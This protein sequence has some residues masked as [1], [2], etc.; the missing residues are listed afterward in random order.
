M[1]MLTM[2]L[3]PLLLRVCQLTSCAYWYKFS[4]T[5]SSAWCCV[6]WCQ[7]QC[8]VLRRLERWSSSNRTQSRWT[9]SLYRRPCSLRAEKST[10][11][12]R[13]RRWQTGSS[14]SVWSLL[15]VQNTT[16][17][18]SWTQNTEMTTADEV[19]STSTGGHRQKWWR[20]A[21]ELL[22]SPRPQSLTVHTLCRGHMWNKI[23]SKLFHPSSTSDWNTFISECG[24]KLAW[25]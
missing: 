22:W 9:P 14:C 24:S 12:S 15:P 16:I 21:A 3:L 8:A 6:C 4:P 18:S 5:I 23:I 10:S 7:C 2:S 19:E 11:G 20:S 13:R 25:N 1:S 17:Q